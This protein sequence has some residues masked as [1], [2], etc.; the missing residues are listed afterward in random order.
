MPIR[1]F[2]GVREEQR[3]ELRERNMERRFYALAAAVREHE[4]RVHRASSEL[5]PRDAELYRRV[6][7]LCGEPLTGEQEVVA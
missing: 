7:Q 2:E 5:D 3:S 4:A 6:R 1:F